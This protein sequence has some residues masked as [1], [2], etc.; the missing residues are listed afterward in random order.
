[1]SGNVTSWNTM[2]MI[3]AIERMPEMSGFYYC[4]TTICNFEAFGYKQ[5]KVTLTRKIDH[6]GSTRAEK[7]HSKVR[8]V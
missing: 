7:D 8:S 6:S 5:S 4:K 3:Q 1:M 2:P